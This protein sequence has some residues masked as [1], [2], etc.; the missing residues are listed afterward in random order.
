[1]WDSYVRGS[2][3]SP[4]SHIAVA[5]IVT[6]FKTIATCYCNLRLK[7]NLKIVSF[8]I[9]RSGMDRDEISWSN[10]SDNVIK[11]IEGAKADVI[12]F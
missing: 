4:S 10:R 3:L 12:E 11:W 9:R 7:N 2:P 8:N 6:V 1:M 5:T